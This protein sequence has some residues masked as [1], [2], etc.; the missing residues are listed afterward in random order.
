MARSRSSVDL[1]T[2]L[3]IVVA[4]FLITLGLIAIIH[5]DS[6]MARSSVGPTIR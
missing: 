4:A 5:Y 2:I 3:Q 6:D 1:V